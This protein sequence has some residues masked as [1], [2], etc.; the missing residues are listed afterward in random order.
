MG[1]RKGQKTRKK[2]KEEKVKKRRQ[3]SGRWWVME[4][5]GAGTGNVLEKYFQSFVMR[6]LC[7]AYGLH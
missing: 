5:V 1:I 7:K 3:R 2:K 4:V 6:S